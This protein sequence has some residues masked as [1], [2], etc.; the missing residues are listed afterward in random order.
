MDAP[1]MVEARG[2]AERLERRLGALRR[3]VAVKAGK[4]E[5]AVETLDPDL[6]EKNARQLTG[7]AWERCRPGDQRG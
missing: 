5:P 3:A 7:H 2:A 6:L 1:G 4:A